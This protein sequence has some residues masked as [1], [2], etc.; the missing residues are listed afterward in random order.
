LASDGIGAFA[1]AEV[2]KLMRIEFQT[3][4]HL[5]LA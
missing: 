1:L 5:F 3:A 4:M 2:N